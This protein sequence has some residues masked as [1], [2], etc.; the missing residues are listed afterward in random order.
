ME[1]DGD[2]HPQYQEE[3]PLYG[4]GESGTIDDQAPQDGGSTDNSPT[5]PQQGSPPNNGSETTQAYGPYAVSGSQWQP[6][7][8]GNST[9][10]APGEYHFTENLT[11]HGT[12]ASPESVNVDTSPS[13]NGTASGV[14]NT[15]P[16]CSETPI[17]EMDGRQLGE[18][19]IDRGLTGES[20]ELIMRQDLNGASWMHM[21]TSTST[22]GNAAMNDLWEEIG[23]K[24]RMTRSRLTSEAS[25][26]GQKWKIREQKLLEKELN[27]INPKGRDASDGTEKTGGTQDTQD[28]TEKKP[29][30][31]AAKVHYAPKIPTYD[32]LSTETGAG[33]DA[34]QVYGKTLATWTEPFSTELSGGIKR[35][36]NRIDE[37]TLREIYFGMSKVAIQL[38]TELGGHLFSTAPKTTQ[39]EL[40]RDTKREM[41]G[42][43]SSLKILWSW[44]TLV[45]SNSKSRMTAALSKWLTRKPTTRPQ[46]LY[47]DLQKF[48]RDTG[49]MS[50]LGMGQTTDPLFCMLIE[51]AL[52]NLV[53][54]LAKDTELLKMLTVPYSAVSKGGNVE[55]M[56][57]VVEACALEMLGI[58]TSDQGGSGPRRGAPRWP[59][60]GGNTTKTP[61]SQQ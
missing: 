12:S 48:N 54:T 53:S 38:D 44:M 31:P 24:S 55:E 10:E 11:P 60:G 32:P 20:T 27:E 42:R 22:E 52:D 57:K 59:R 43:T 21:I 34:L 14:P 33:V 36:M 41:D 23:V 4:S 61:L 8:H 15:P 47:G 35:I 2:N 1:I 7:M 29:F 51:Q 58:P 46:D 26:G 49:T 9:P 37:P 5:H 50:R 45:D 56:I 28:N 6:S 19:L 39:D 17:Y 18:Y 30:Q 40:Y 13:P 3:N 25:L 16:G